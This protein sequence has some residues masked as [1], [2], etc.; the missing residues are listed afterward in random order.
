M[1]N[2]SNSILIQ[3]IVIFTYTGLNLCEYFE[4]VLGNCYIYDSGK[5][6]KMIYKIVKPFV[7]PLVV[8]KINFIKSS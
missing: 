3:Y 2:P 5:L 6:F 1:S 7:D 4:E 8:P